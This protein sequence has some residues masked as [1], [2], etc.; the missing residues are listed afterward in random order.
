[1]YPSAL[2]L[3]GS[4]LVLICFVLGGFALGRFTLDS[5]RAATWQVQI[6][7]ILGFFLL[8]A[9]VVRYA[10]AGA[11]AG[12]GAA[13]NAFRAVAGS[14][15]PSVRAW[16]QPGC[17]PRERPPRCRSTAPRGCSSSS[18]SASWGSRT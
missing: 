12:S 9:S 14:M 10:Q 6:A 8:V 16:F 15:P 7:L 11:A 3:L 18:G 13:T 4:L 17:S 2:V 5:Y 1:M